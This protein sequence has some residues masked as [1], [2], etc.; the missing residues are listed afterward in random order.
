MT[1]QVA[2]TMT[3]PKGRELRVILTESRGKRSV[4]LRAFSAPFSP[5][6]VR[7]AEREGLSLPVSG[8]PDLIEALQAA[9]YQ[10]EQM[11]WRGDHV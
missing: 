8:L 2:A 5:A 4:E 9:A 6:N 7:A 3:L 10:A 11:G 1:P